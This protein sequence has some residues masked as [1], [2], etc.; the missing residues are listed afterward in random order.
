MGGVFFVAKMG[1]LAARTGFKYQVRSRTDTRVLPPG[2]SATFLRPRFSTYQGDTALTSRTRIA[3][4]HLWGY[5]EADT[6]RTQPW[7]RKAKVKTV[8]KTLA[9]PQGLEPRY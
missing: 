7:I 4:R 8:P 2:F 9:A 1:V 6:T 5:E 3:N